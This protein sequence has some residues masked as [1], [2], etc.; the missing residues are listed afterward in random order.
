MEVVARPVFIVVLADPG[1]HSR[2]RIFE[3]CRLPFGRHAT[4]LRTSS[5]I[6]FGISSMAS[7][8]VRPLESIPATV[9]A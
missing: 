3:K 4:D 9:L 2:P 8:R 1:E 6:S 7:S 5:E